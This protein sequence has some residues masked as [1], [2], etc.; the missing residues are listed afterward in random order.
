MRGNSNWIIYLIIGAV[1]LGA[2]SGGTLFAALPGGFTTLSLSQVDFR[3][4]NQFFN[5]PLWVLSVVQGG[6]GQNAVGTFAAS[7]IEDGGNQADNN[8]RIDVNYQ[9]QACEYT[10]KK[11]V[12]QPDVF[13]FQPVYW[14]S[15]T[16]A[17]TESEA[18]Q[19]CPDLFQSSYGSLN[20]IIHP[21]GFWCINAVPLTGGIDTN[22]GEAS[23]VTE[24]TV[25]LTSGDK[26]ETVNIDTKG[27]S[28]GFFDQGNAYYIW[29]GNLYKDKCPGSVD[30]NYAFYRRGWLIGDEGAYSTYKILSLSALQSL[31]ANCAPGSSQCTQAVLNSLFTNSNNQA[32]I[33]VSPTTV[34]DISEQSLNGAILEV[35]VE[36]PVSSPVYTFFVKAD[37]IGIEQPE[38]DVIIT[39]INADPIKTYGT[40]NV[41]LKNLGETGNV[42]V[43]VTCTD[44]VFEPDGNVR[45]IQ[46]SSGSATNILIP[47]SFNSDV[48]KTTSCNAYAKTVKGEKIQLFF[49]TG[50]PESVCNPGHKT[51]D[52]VNNEIIVCNS[53]G[54]GYD[55]YK[56]CGDNQICDFK[57]AE[58]YCRDKDIPPGTGDCAPWDIPCLIKQWFDNL[59]ETLGYAAMLLVIGVVAY[60]FL[61]R[62]K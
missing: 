19:H 4:S 36:S 16:T 35:L 25:T 56:S 8:L 22:L 38:P 34:G 3:S 60:L 20:Q 9:K 7:E 51:C 2:V 39:S 61:F 50:E 29:N 48:K 10:I 41:G 1:A 24:S 62:R 28:Q 58:P 27:D 37:W 44:S 26:V 31:S 6:L 30:D 43:W 47:V 57:N 33:A 46:L 21:F 40:V 49:L 59:A 15:F 45:T 23:I 53:A 5:Q 14:S 32:A 18:R 54:S 42:D 55:T 12:S 17:V 13:T 52:P 11:D